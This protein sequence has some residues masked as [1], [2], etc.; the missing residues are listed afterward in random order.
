MMRASPHRPFISSMISRPV[1]SGSIMS[2]M[3]TLGMFSWA[4][5]SP[6]AALVA[7]TTW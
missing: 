4:A 6:A 3:T 5:F 7:V 1:R 2:R